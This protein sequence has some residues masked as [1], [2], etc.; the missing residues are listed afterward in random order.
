[1]ISL[2]QVLGWRISVKVKGCLTFIN[3]TYYKILP[4]LIKTNQKQYIWLLF[5][6]QKIARVDRNLFPRVRENVVQYMACF[7]GVKVVCLL[8][9]LGFAQ[10]VEKQGRLSIDHV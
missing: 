2:F 5:G 9:P 3:A 4:F 1:M 10:A 7:G 8:L 6:M